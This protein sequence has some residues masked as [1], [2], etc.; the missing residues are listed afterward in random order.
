[1]RHELVT[2]DTSQQPTVIRDSDL[3][4]HLI[5]ELLAGKKSIRIDDPT[6]DMPLAFDAVE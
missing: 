1:M 3:V 5:E 4:G 2:C 6:S